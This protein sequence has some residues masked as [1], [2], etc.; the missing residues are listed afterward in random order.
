MFLLFILMVMTIFLCLLLIF[1]TILP[2]HEIYSLK[3][4]PCRLGL[5][6]DF[7][8]YLVLKLKSFL[9][10]LWVIVLQLVYVFLARLTNFIHIH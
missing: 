9:Q 2:P 10:L 6:L 7:L 5:H 8:L 1:G 4:F 3:F